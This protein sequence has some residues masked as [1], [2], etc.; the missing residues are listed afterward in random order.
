MKRGSLVTIVISLIICCILAGCSKDGA[1]DV[2]DK[3]KD[4]TA[5][6]KADKETEEEEEK[7]G[8]VEKETEK[9]FGYDMDKAADSLKEMSDALSGF[10]WAFMMS[11]SD[12][13]ADPI[14]DRDLELSDEDKIRASVL[15]CDGDNVIDS[16]FVLGMGGFSE[17][18][19]G[20]T[21]PEDGGYHGMSV[22]REEVEKT[23]LDLFGTKALWD[24][25]PIGPECYLY[26][27]V[28]YTDG[29]DTYVL[30]VE[31]EIETEMS[32]EIH[33]CTV[34]EEGG[35]Y[36]GKVNMFWGYW[37]ELEQKPGYSNYVL[38]YTL[39][40]SNESKYG[41][42]ISAMNVK[43]IESDNDTDTEGSEPVQAGN[44]EYDESF[45][46]LWITAFKE[47]Q[48]ALDLT[49]KLREKGLEA[50]SI[51]SV[52]YENLSKDPYWCVTIGKSG[53]EA[54][55]Q[56]LIEDA[57]KA[58]YKDAYVKYTGGQLSHRIYYYMYSPSDAVITTSKVTLE[59]VPTEALSGTYED[60]GPMTLTADSDTVFDKT[61]DMQFF[62]GYKE[63]ESP[64][65]WFISASGEDIMGV[66]E[67]G[68]T[69]NHID[70]FYGSYWWD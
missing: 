16:T 60:E 57:K 32:L 33:E 12:Y 21:A 5:S 45:F 34:T 25:L 47:R 3:L 30:I 61:C 7:D 64:L 8:T 51:Y 23:C 48:D 41:M 56:A 53:S 50:Y 4:N 52:E 54:E 26:D 27:A 24:D 15:A 17:D 42:I 46:G 2:S 62:P 55:A 1:G 22:S 39:Q 36:I 69:G 68:I 38:T 18:I 66:F 63:G 49:D 70:S 9:E 58:G 29:N 28:K 37:G 44:E 20:E 40:P 10:M 13:N 31:Q 43:M 35:E 65:E 67:V 11:E 14:K 19:S 6:L 59:E